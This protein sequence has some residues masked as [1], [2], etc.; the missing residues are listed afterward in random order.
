MSQVFDEKRNV[1]PVTIVKAGPCYVL[2]KKGKEG[3]DNY[4]ATV[5]GFE[6]IEKKN[7]VKKTMKGKEFKY[8]REFRKDNDFNVGDEINVSSFQEGEKVKVQGFSKGKGFSGVVKRWN[9]TMQPA[10]HGN[11]HTQ[12]AMGSTGRRF[13]QR[14][15]K[16]RKM[17]GRLGY[18]MVTVKNLKVQSVD[19]E[20][21]TILLKGAIPGAPGTLL[22]ISKV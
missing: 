7:K 17:P 4:S 13:P 11:K 14:V 12:R 15:T 20:E 21:N 6:K 18:E 22:K 10:T 1:I 9:F 5:V 19:I 16:G 3:K 2:Q 8:I